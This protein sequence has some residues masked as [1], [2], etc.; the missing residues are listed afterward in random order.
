MSQPELFI[1]LQHIDKAGI[2]TSGLYRP[3]WLCQKRGGLI[4]AIA[5]HV[6]RAGSELTF[7]KRAAIKERLAEAT[8]RPIVCDKDCPELTDEQLAEFR[9][10]NGM[11][12]EERARAIEATEAVF[13]DGFRF[14]D[15]FSA[16]QK[17]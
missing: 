6:H 5:R 9:S 17:I 11:T 15:I 10:V 7:K 1:R 8:G 3:G 13:M 16:T 4:M 14:G 12:M 2:M